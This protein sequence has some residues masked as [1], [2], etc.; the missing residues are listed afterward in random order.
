MTGKA[1][2][3]ALVVPRLPVSNIPGKHQQQQANSTRTRL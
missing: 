1:A 3:A 2:A